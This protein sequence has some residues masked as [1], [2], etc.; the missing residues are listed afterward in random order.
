[1]RRTHSA[2]GEDEEQGKDVDARVVRPLLSRAACWSLLGVI[3]FRE[4][5]EEQFG[6]YRGP[7]RICAEQ[8]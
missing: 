8:R 3:A 4:L 5:R 1:M 6:R 7:L 2:Q